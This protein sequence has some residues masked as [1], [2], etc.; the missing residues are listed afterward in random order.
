MELVRNCFRNA[1]L[2]PKETE[3]LASVAKLGG[4]NASGLRLL[5]HELLLSASQ[6]K[7][8]YPA[9]DV[10]EPVLDSDAGTCYLHDSEHQVYQGWCRN[11]RMLLSPA[12]EERALGGRRRKK[13][14]A[15]MEF[16]SGRCR[17]IEVGSCPVQSDTVT[18]VELELCCFVGETKSGTS[19]PEYPLHV[20][21]DRQ[22][23]LPLEV[24]MHK[25]L[26]AS[27]EAFHEH[28]DHILLVSRSYLNTR[29]GQ[30]RVRFWIRFCSGVRDMALQEAMINVLLPPC[31]LLSRTRET[32]HK[33]TF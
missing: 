16:R 4:H 8:L 18:R 3:Q 22:P 20:A 12:E 30:L 1:P 26:R 19:V 29:L 28:P 27:W 5:V 15:P 11:P 33:S 9:D 6:L 10:A 17:S 2:T 31:R 25:E 24:E 32:R 14:T 23:P 13:V 21:D 7:H